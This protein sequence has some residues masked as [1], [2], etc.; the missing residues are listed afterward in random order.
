MNRPIQNSFNSC[1]RRRNLRRP[2]ICFCLLL[3]R[4]LHGTGPGHKYCSSSSGRPGV[5]FFTA[6]RSGA[7]PDRR[8]WPGGPSRGPGRRRHG[9]R[10]WRGGPCARR[11][12]PACRWCNQMYSISN[13]LI[14]SKITVTVCINAGGAVASSGK[15][16]YA[17]CMKFAVQVLALYFI[18]PIVIYWDIPR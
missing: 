3:T 12:T 2:P 17:V 10:G 13:S 9:R 11:P 5:N 4:N 15:N 8:Q 16:N 18:L 1:R 14:P 7:T 6:L